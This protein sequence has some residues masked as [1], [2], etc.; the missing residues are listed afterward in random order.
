MSKQCPRWLGS[1]TAMCRQS[2]ASKGNLGILLT[3]VCNN[4]MS[5]FPGLVSHRIK[6]EFGAEV[7]ST[8]R[9]TGGDPGSGGFWSSEVRQDHQGT[10][11]VHGHHH[12]TVYF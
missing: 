9:Q 12:R 11:E 6:W 3:A 5:D 10:S 2:N 1:R 8:V 4:C 7:A